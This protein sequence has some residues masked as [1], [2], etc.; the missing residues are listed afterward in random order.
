MRRCSGGAV[1][2]ARLPRAPRRGDE[3]RRAA[4]TGAASTAARARRGGR[5][6]TPS[7]WYG[8]RMTWPVC[9][10]TCWLPSKDQRGSSKMR[11]GLQRM[12]KGGRA[13]AGW[14]RV[15]PVRA[16]R[17]RRRRL[18]D[19]RRFRCADR[20]GVSGGDL[21]VS[22]GASR[23]IL[24]LR[25]RAHR[26]TGSD[27]RAAR[28]PRDGTWPPRPRSSWA[29]RAGADGRSRGAARRGSPFAVAAAAAGARGRGGTTERN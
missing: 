21:R 5:G 22:A 4:P 12:I 18:P 23:K 8:L 19:A 20:S 13:D 24:P 2:G 1:G 9:G 27:G 14:R 25:S 10:R 17:R 15:G 6:E 29:P 26:E 3:H 28:G 7:P 11:G 16:A